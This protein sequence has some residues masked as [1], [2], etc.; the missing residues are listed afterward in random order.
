M[1]S[2]LKP[3]RNKIL[4]FIF[5]L[6][7]LFILAG[8]LLFTS[9]LAGEDHW[10]TSFL[11]WLLVFSTLPLGQE[12]FNYI[13]PASFLMFIFLIGIMAPYAL[14]CIIVETKQRRMSIYKIVSIVVSIFVLASILY[15][16]A[17][18]KEFLYQT[19]LEWVHERCGTQLA[20]HGTFF[21]QRCE[22]DGEEIRDPYVP[23][24]PTTVP[25]Y[26][27]GNVRRKYVVFSNDLLGRYWPEAV[28]RTQEREVANLQEAVT[29]CAEAANI[30]KEIAGKQ[31]GERVKEQC[32]YS[33]RE[34]F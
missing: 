4:G 19:Y 1:L 8:L 3:S 28:D 26:C 11:I 14:A 15:V 25:Y 27:V 32:E 22:C 16:M 20:Y 33:A 23:H 2:F 31:T 29:A 13:S 7:L 12:N 30:V 10:L 34:I 24:D 6:F 9:Y 18:P 5:I 21:Y 17:L